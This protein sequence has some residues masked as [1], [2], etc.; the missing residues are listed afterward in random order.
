MKRY[1]ALILSVI[2]VMTAFSGCSRK[3]GEGDPDQKKVTLT[4]W[5][6][7]ED[8]PDEKGWLP[9]M[10]NTFNDAHPEWDITFKY[11]VCS[12]GDAGKNIS[13]DPSGSA[14]VY[15]FANDQLGTL[16]QA[17]A[18]S[19]LGGS[20]L[21]E[22]EKSASEAM[23]ESV[24][25]AD[26]GVYGVP[27]SGNTWFMFYNKSVFSEEDVKSLDAMIKKGKVAFP[28]TNSWYTGA[29]Y[30]A[31]G[32]TLFGDDGRD[33]AAG[34]DFGG[35]EGL[36]ATQYLVAL[37][38]NPNFI[39]DAEGAGL[40]G[41]LDGSVGAI[42]SGSWD[43]Q[44][45][46]KALGDDYGAAPLPTANI[47]GSEKQLLSFSGSKAIGVNPSC[48]NPEVA[49]A[50]AAFLG[51]REAQREH[52][53]MRNIIPTDTDLLESEELMGDIA[54]QAQNLTINK[55]SIIQPSIPEMT[56]YWVPVENMGKAIVNGEVTEKNAKE[57]TEAFNDSLKASM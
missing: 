37:A 26:G 53:R 24:R 9:V 52:Y 19:R 17:N 44:K 39:N 45:I 6:P 15:F 3:G 16:L 31:N 40:S 55:T 51:S 27:F 42:F 21:E 13:A 29:F 22:I 18:I 14:D 46:E 35:K 32:C 34:I 12:E 28:L 4:V 23:V 49:V 2:F 5:A 57:K 38:N 47:G 41:L 36:E 7:Q 11:G 33:A 50:L 56:A 10:C 25:G 54:A 1:I 30:L 48:K 8:Q 20:T 43:A